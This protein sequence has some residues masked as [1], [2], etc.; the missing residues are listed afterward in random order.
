MNEVNLIHIIESALFNIFKYIN[1]ILQQIIYLI[2]PLII[3]EYYL[4][5]WIIFKELKY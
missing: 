2:C 4:Y 1:D 5:Y 3:K